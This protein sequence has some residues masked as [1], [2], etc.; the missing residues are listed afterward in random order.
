MSPYYTRNID[1]THEMADVGLLL[2]GSM[3]DDGLELFNEW[4]I[5]LGIEKF[6]VA[7]LD[8][9]S[10]NV[11]FDCDVK[12]TN[13]L[14]I[15]M[16]DSI[17]ERQTAGLKEYYNGNSDIKG[18]PCKTPNEFELKFRIRLPSMLRKVANFQF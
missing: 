9:D 8:P 7:I 1:R 11:F 10:L 4:V 13:C 6:A 12:K 2:S 17:D 16:F 18:K 15:C 3:T 14:S 5:T